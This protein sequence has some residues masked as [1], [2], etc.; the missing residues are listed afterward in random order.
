MFYLIL[1]LLIVQRLGEL[2]LARRNERLVRAEGAYEVGADHYKWIVLMHTGWFFSMIVEYQF[3]APPAEPYMLILLG[4]FLLAQVMRYYVI[5]TLGKHWNTRILIL[6]GST[7]VRRGLYRFIN[8]PNYWI[9]RV[10]LLIVPLMFGLYIT[11]V[12]FSILNY[13]MLRR[14]IRMEDEALGALRG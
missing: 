4:I 13:F 7:R 2:L 10:E 11:A 5:V 14:R 1:I 8:H 6:P 3:S 9:V 12:V